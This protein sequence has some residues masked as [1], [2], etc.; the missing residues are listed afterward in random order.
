MDIHNPGL[1]VELSD[2][3]DLL[4]EGQKLA[5]DIRTLQ[6]MRPVLM[7]SAA[8]ALADSAPLYY[9]YRESCNSADLK[10][11]SDRNLRYDI[12]VVPSIMLGTEFNKTLGHYHPPSTARPGFSFPELYEVLSGTAH[13]LLQQPGPDFKGVQRVIMVECPEGEKV[14]IPPNFGHVTLNMGA[15]VL[16]MDNLVERNFK[17]VYEPYIKQKG[18]AYYVTEDG[19]T[20]NPAYGDSS[21]LPKLETFLAHEFNR[22]VNPELADFLDGGYNYEL[23]AENPDDFGFLANPNDIELKE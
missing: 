14:L 6:Q 3:F 21:A 23:F 2:S 12:T 4:V 15:D 7:D 1:N 18:G 17:S 19:D 9:M 22:M 20:P 13:Y 8:V 5:P 11:Y 10:T 16:V